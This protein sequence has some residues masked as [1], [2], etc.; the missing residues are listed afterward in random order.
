MIRAWNI[1]CLM[2]SPKLSDTLP[3]NIPCE[4]LDILEAGIR[5]S[6]WVLMLVE[7]SSF[8]ILT[9]LR[10]WSTLPKRS[11]RFFAVSPTTCPEKMLPMV[12]WITRASFSP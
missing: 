9:D 12:F 2:V 10:C 11:E 6:S 1:F 5:E 7:V 8:V 4:R 3:T